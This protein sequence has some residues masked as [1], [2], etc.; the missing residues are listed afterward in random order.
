MGGW[1]PVLVENAV[2]FSHTAFVQ[3][4]NI[5]FADKTLCVSLA[6]LKASLRFHL[7]SQDTA[8]ALPRS[9]KNGKHSFSQL[10]TVLG[11]GGKDAG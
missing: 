3:L 2:S 10:S 7:G 4:Y 1:P 9:E 5:F 6:S 11:D 8:A